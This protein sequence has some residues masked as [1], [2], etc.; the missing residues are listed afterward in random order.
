MLNPTVNSVLKS[1]QK[2]VKT[3]ET[4][5]DNNASKV[6]L[7]NED[8][9]KIESRITTATREQELARVVSN[10]IKKLIEV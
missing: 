5:A 6:V 2:T 9:E 8:K 7:L 4:I 10:N 3:L 1:F